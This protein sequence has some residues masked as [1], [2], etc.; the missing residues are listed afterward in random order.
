MPTGTRISIK[1]NSA[2]NPTMATVS[3]LM[4]LTRPA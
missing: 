1:A 3:P 2:T 4:P